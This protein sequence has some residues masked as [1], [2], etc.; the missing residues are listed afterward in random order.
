MGDKTRITLCMAVL[1]VV[2]LNPFAG[3]V[4]KP[5]EDSFTAAGVGRTILQD[6]ESFEFET[7]GS[8]LRSTASTVA[9]SFIHLFLFAMIMA[10]IFIYGE[11]NIDKK[12]K[13]MRNFWVHRKQVDEEMKRGLKG[14]EKVTKHLTLAVDSLGR[15]VPTSRFE[16]VASGLWQLFHQVLHRTRIAQWF[17][18][19]AGG[20]TA[21]SGVRKNLSSVRKECAKAYH[22]LN[23]VHFCQSNGT[24]NLYGFVLALSALNLAES[25]DENENNFLCH[26]YAL[27]SLR[28]RLL[29]PNRL[30]GFISRYYMYKAKRTLKK[31]DP[32]DPS[33]NWLLSSTGREFVKST[34]WQFGQDHSLLT[35]EPDDLNPL[36][37]VGL[38][39]RDQQ[40]KKALSIVVSPGQATGRV[41][42]VL[43]L[44]QLVDFNNKCVKPGLI[45][46]CQDNVTKWWSAVLSSTACS[47]LDL[48][49][50]EREFYQVVECE[51]K[52]SDSNEAA[53]GLV[54]KSCMAAYMACH[55]SIEDF[56]DR[57]HYCDV[58]TD[59]LEDITEY[60]LRKQEKLDAEDK[61]ELTVTK[62]CTLIFK[63]SLP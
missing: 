42:E 21:D 27:F 49:E 7:W 9:V 12:S 35:Q 53:L 29:L 16:L 19:R 11:A 13:E 39:F 17:E 43:D 18:N 58:A 33:L 14:H 36:T 37:R 47:M 44:M 62:V 4:E 57:S 61:N 2:A 26:V 46:D 55:E 5:I 38:Y 51:P 63:K 25:M 48:S 45:T 30:F 15:P 59:R 20:F 28:L 56:K 32:I 3:F 23:E 6:K 8:F 50:K 60:L 52:W 24:D 40:L 31:N 34:N 22:Q 1:A 10:K 54:V 41:D